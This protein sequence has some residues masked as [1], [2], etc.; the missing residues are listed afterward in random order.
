ME[1]EYRI[2]ASEKKKLRNI[3]IQST[4]IKNSEGFG[5]EISG[6]FCE[7]QTKE[8]NIINLRVSKVDHMDSSLTY[9]GSNGTFTVSGSGDD[10]PFCFHTHPIQTD[11]KGN[12]TNY[13]NIISNEDLI[14][15]VQDSYL[16]NGLT[17]N[18]NGILKFDMILCPLGIY[19]YAA[20]EKVIKTYI[21]FEPS[22]TIENVMNWISVRILNLVIL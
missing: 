12:L 3:W 19:V 11:R 15:V 18:P 10:H 20:T 13:P 8:D 17:S 21:E 9:K 2:T 7:Q 14:G 22:I 16:N 4:E 6:I 1:K 5:E